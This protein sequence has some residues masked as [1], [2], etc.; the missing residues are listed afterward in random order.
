MQAQKYKIRNW[1]QYNKALIQRGSITIWVEEE[2]LRKWLST[3]CSGRAGRPET[4][5]NDA[6]LMLLVLREMFK[7]TLDLFGN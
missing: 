5:S 7:L 6:I 3:S 1:P 4:Y 2:A